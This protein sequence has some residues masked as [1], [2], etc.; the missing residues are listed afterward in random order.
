MADGVVCRSTQG[1]LILFPRVES[2]ADCKTESPKAKRSLETTVLCS[3]G[4]LRAG[5]SLIPTRP[6]L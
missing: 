4:Q 3:M 5:H 2:K 6:L 1:L